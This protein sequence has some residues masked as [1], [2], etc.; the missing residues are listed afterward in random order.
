M[1]CESPAGVFLELVTASRLEERPPCYSSLQQR[2]EWLQFL[3]RTQGVGPVAA[4]V[5]SR[6]G[7]HLGYFFG[8][9]KRV[10]PLRVL[11][12]PLPGW[13]TQYMGFALAESVSVDSVH[14]LNALR[15]FAWTDLGC[16]HIEIRDRHVGRGTLAEA[17]LRVQDGVQ[18]G[19]EVSLEP[20]EEDLWMGLK[21][22]CRRAV[23]KATVSGLTVSE[24]DPNRAFVDEY[25]G[26][27]REVFDR[28]GL[29]PTYGRTRVTGLIESLRPS[30]RLLALQ[31]E[32]PSGRPIANG[33]F[34][35]GDGTAYFWGAYSRQDSLHLRPNDLMHWEVMRRARLL[36]CSRYDL[37]GAGAYK[38]KFGAYPI[39]VP[40]GRLSRFPVLEAARSLRLH[41]FRLGQRVR[42]RGRPDAPS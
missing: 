33:L 42:A 5:L 26:Q 7:E 17:G 22:S 12:S 4:E 35:H 34:P 14:L 24:V 8:A 31:V 1:G 20:S 30:G 23:R 2:P 32:T 27:M 6:G 38:E 13:T 19:W 11:G 40:S 29:T 39:D 21:P 3:A 37:C 15:R 36:G 16:V 10:G 25:M 28:Q 9:V 41:G 18:T